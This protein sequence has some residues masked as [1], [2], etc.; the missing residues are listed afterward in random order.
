[1]LSKLWGRPTARV[2]TTSD[3]HVY[4]LNYRKHLRAR[5]PKRALLSYL[6]EPIA[7]ELGGE[8]IIRFSNSGLGLSW[9]QVLNELGYIVD[10]I[11]WDDKDFVPAKKYDLVV[12]HGG[13]N[14]QHIST[15]LQ[16]NPPIIHFLTGSYWKFNNDEEDKR[17]NDFY[18][19]QGV[20]LARDRYIYDSE[21][22]VN[23]AANGIIVLGDPSMRSTYPANY[24]KVLTINN[25]SY[26]DDHFDTYKKDYASARQNFLFFAGSGNIHKGLDLLLDAFKG[27]SLHLYIVTVPDQELLAAYKDVLKQPNIHL[28]G[29]VGMR[30]PEF[31]EVMDKC[32]FVILPS[33]SEGQAGSVVEA[34]N[35]G[36]IPIVSKATRLDARAYGV[37]LETVSIRSI[38]RVVKKMSVLSPAEVKKLSLKTRTTAQTEHSAAHFRSTLKQLIIE[39]LGV[40]S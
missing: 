39:L 4:V 32:A 25:A 27:L 34:M 40:L 26:P 31:Y 5:R 28:V 37:V 19:R 8:K 21:D 23:E 36:L 16:G 29:E 38:Q 7:S 3:D 10:I 22:T 33:C 6:P 2:V 9:A 14:F 20:K 30:S 35:Q 15:N 17:L 12:F 13:K 24:K 18:K 11:S 1:M